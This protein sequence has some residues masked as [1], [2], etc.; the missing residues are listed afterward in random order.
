MMSDAI[1][2]IRDLYKKHG[3]FE[4]LRGVSLDVHRGE[5]FGLLGPNGAGKT[6]LLSILACL[7]A[8]NSGEVTLEGQPLRIDDLAARGSIG[9][10]TQ[11]LALYRDL[12]A[13]ENLRFFGKLYGLRGAELENRIDAGI[14]LAGLRDKA[15]HPVRTYSGGMQRRLNLAVA[16]VHRPKL[17]LLD[18]PT[19]GV[20]PQSRNH[21]F[22]RVQELNREGMTVIYTT[23]YMEEVQRLCTRIA[24]LDGGRLV[25]SD[26]LTNLLHLLERSLTL[27]FRT[28]PAPLRRE[29]EQIAGLRVAQSG[30]NTLSIATADLE[31]VLT[32]VVGRLPELHLEL[33]RVET[34]EPNL[35]RVFLHLTEHTLRD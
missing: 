4:A 27:R 17:L 11:E 25:A 6:T 19:T 28:D 13:R 22:E 14:E 23:H 3:D 5:C 26:T 9:L 16:V 12:S 18:E 29:L 34:H 2:R 31:G 7:S 8:P 30:D 10:A 35:E 20:D 21:I 1:L 33:E 24:I 15:S 32:R